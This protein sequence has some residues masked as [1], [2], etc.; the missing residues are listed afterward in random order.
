M[1][2]KEITDKLNTELGNIEAGYPDTLYFVHLDRAKEIYGVD[3][4]KPFYAEYMRIFAKQ[5]EEEK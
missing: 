4:I 2:K 1:T 5:L 3:F